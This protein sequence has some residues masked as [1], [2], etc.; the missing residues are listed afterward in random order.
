[1]LRYVA[2]AALMATPAAAQVTYPPSVTAADLA[3]LSA[4]IPVPA[5]TV[6]PAEMP[7]GAAGAANTFRRGDAVNNRVT[8]TGVFTIG[9]GGVILCG[10]STTCNW[11]MA[12]PAGAASYPVFFTP[13]GATALPGVKCKVTSSSNTGFTGAQCVQSV[14]SISL[15]GA[16]VEIAATT[17][18][19][20]FI[21][22]LPSTQA[23]R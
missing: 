23:N 9:A 7:G 14:A 15:L 12:L 13:I 10:G 18:T 1:M 21:L 17:G 8:R 3:A 22:S 2:V 19:Q 6:P 16:A 4:Q 20:V 11:D 5:D